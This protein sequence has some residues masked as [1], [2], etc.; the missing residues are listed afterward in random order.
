MFFSTLLLFAVTEFFLSLSPG[1]AVFLVISQ[2]VKVGARSSLLSVLG[3]LTGN[4]IYFAISAI[5]VGAILVTSE[6]I[7]S[8]I[9]WAG[10]LYLIYLGLKLI[11][12][13][14]LTNAS[15][16]HIAVDISRH[17]LFRQGLFT[18]LGNPKAILFFTAL[19]PQFIDV[20]RA[21]LQQFALL[22]LVS[23]LVELPVLVFY[24]W[25]AGRMGH[26]LRDSILAKWLDRLAGTFLIG[27]GLRLAFTEK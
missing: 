24:G 9:K 26:L 15:T 17:K 21:P 8:I 23:V 18:Q 11:W 20:E 2:G 6:T 1:P 7:F 13:T 10:A 27:A 12:D 25:L 19:L 22:G 4:V 14:L 16:E 3:I 5:G